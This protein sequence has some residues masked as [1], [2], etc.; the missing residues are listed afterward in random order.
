MCD[1]I[2][3]DEIKTISLNANKYEYRIDE[4]ETPNGDY[5]FN[6]ITLDAEKD[7]QD[8]FAEPDNCGY[9]IINKENVN[10]YTIS[11]NDN[12]RLELIIR[13]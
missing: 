2:G 6:V 3:G 11:L 7:L 5:L 10:K 1:Q 13:S 4:Y 8:D 9:M 12:N